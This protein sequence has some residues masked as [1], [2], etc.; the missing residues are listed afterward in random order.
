MSGVE[1]AGVTESLITGDFQTPVGW[2]SGHLQ[3]IRSR[4]VRRRRD[5]DRYGSHRSVLVEVDD[6]T[7]DRLVVQVHRARRTA[8]S[9]PVG[10]LVVLI[11]GLGG[12]VESDY[13]RAMTQGLLAAGFNVARV[14]LRGVGLSGQTSTSWYHAGRTE[15]LRAVLRG[16]AAQPEAGGN[17][18]G[19]P[20]LAVVGFSLGGSMAIKLM[21][22]PHE[23][24]PI[25][26]AVSV[27]APLDLAVGSVYLHR[28]AFGMYERF[29]VSGLK[30]Q[31][32]APGPG[33]QARVTEQERSA[34]VRARSLA[35][36]DDAL[37]AP[38]NGWRDSAEYYAKNS[39]GPFLARIDLPTLVIHSVDDPMI[40]A[41]PYRAI[42]WES[43][44]GKGFVQRAI[45]ARGGHVGF[46]ERGNPLPW[47]VGQAVT[48]L[49][50]ISRFT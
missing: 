47:Y 48:F 44:E 41:S 46:H 18:T 29:I 24:L 17:P 26:A 20:R 37:T 4:V 40:P 25:Y 14:D 12:S 1:S 13:M 6:G 8:G 32:L 2:D 33:G 19:Q 22:E 30:K 15:D 36:F 11:H 16:L 42:D 5:L 3:T 35:D 39:S 43:L 34:I 28:M 27:S 49:S 21:G 10:G 31:S 7:G 38:R 9:A 50:A 23:H 45:T